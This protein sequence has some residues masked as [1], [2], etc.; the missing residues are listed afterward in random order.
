M[1]TKI[2]TEN[3]IKYYDIENKLK[4][5]TILIL[6]SIYKNNTEFLIPTL[7]TNPINITQKIPHPKT[8]LYLLSNQ[9]QN[10][11]INK[12]LFPDLFNTFWIMNTHKYLIKYT[13]NQTNLDQFT[14]TYL[15]Q[16]FDTKSTTTSF[17][18]NIKQNQTILTNFIE[19]LYIEYQQSFL[20]DI[21][22]Q[23]Q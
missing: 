22:N 15:Q 8:W 1:Q 3:L 10:L 16:I 2:A 9:N 11:K 12:N 5:S 21:E 14:Q 6:W 7:I 19:P 4:I 18:N 23:N 17:F 13:K 20:Q